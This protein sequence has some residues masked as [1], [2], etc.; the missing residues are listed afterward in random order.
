MQSSIN[1]IFSV[2]QARVVANDNTVRRKERVWQLERTRWRGTLAGCRVTIC[3]H[4]DGQVSIVY[5]PH[6]VGRYTAEGQSLDE[7]TRRR[8]PPRAARRPAWAL[9]AVALR[10]PSVSAPNPRV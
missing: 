2:Q 3:E 5:G 1:R 10:A 6:V 4:L 9:T 8:C 7:G